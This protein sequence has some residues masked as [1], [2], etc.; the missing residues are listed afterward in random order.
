MSREVK[1]PSVGESV[2]EALLVQWLKNDGDTVKAD[3]P[4]FVIETDKITLEVTADI[5]GELKIKVGEGETVS[6]G[7]VVAV[8]ETSGVHQKETSEKIREQEPEEE[9]PIVPQPPEKE[10]MTDQTKKTES[11]NKK[12][13]ENRETGEAGEKPQDTATPKDNIAPSV[14]RLAQENRVNLSDVTASGPGGRITKGDIML[15]LES[16]GDR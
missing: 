9:T 1:V 7:T 16:S 8:I 15:F 2:T 13:P 14:R 10:E 6:I 11:E 5:D 12:I 3:D 4:L